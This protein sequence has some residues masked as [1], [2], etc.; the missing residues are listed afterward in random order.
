[1]F[2]PLK[3]YGYPTVNAK[4]D[5]LITSCRGFLYFFAVKQALFC[6]L[7]CFV[8]VLVNFLAFPISF[9]ASCTFHVVWENL[10][11]TIIAPGFASLSG[12]RFCPT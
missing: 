1:M 8:F 10:G 6:V 7:V 4:S 5:V 9:L 2:L 12:A 11:I 3:V